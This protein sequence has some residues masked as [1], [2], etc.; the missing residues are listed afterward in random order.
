MKFKLQDLKT[1]RIW[2]AQEKSNAEGL[3]WIR[4]Q[5]SLNL[6]ILWSVLEYYPDNPLIDLWALSGRSNA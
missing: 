3:D 5:Y 1:W 6:D 2:V 4:A